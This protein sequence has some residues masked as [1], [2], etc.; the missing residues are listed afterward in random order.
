[1]PNNDVLRRAIRGALFANAAVAASVSMAAPADVP[2]TAT[3]PTA[4]PELAE[5]VVTGSRITDPTLKSISPVTTISSADIKE[6]GITRIEDLLNSMPQVF[7]DQGSNVSNGATGEAT[8]NLRN[9]GTQRTLVLINGRRLMPGD[10]TQPAA[11]AP[12]LNN[13]PAAL[14]DR[15]DVLTG[16]ASS[17]YGADAVAGVVNFVMNDHFEGVRLDVNAGLY[18]HSQHDTAVSSLVSQAGYPLPSSSVN[19]GQQRDLTFIIGSNLDDNKGNITAYAGYR[20]V[21]AV[22]E[23]QRDFSSCALNSANGGAEYRCGGSSTAATGRFIPIFYIAPNGTVSGANGL[24]G[25]PG[26]FTT[27]PSGIVPWGNQYEYNYAPTNYFQ[28]PDERWTAGSFAHYDFNEHQ[29]AY[30]EF[31]F[32]RD[33]SISQEAAGGAFIGEGNASLNGIPNGL[34]TTNCNNPLLSAA[35]VTALCNGNTAGSAQFYLGRRDVEGGPR[36]QDLEHTSFRVVVGTRGD[37]LDG[38]WHYDTY[39]MEGQT[40]Y[41]QSQTGNFSKTALGNALEVAPTGG[42]LSGVLGCVPYNVYSYG[43]VSTNQLKYLE[44]PAVTTG[45]TEERVIDANLTGDFGKYGLKSPWADSGVKANFGAEWRSEHVGLQVDAEQINF[46]ISG[47]GNPVYPLSAGF[48]VWEL[49]TEIGVPIAEDQP[50]AKSLAFETGYRYSN[51]NVGFSTN[52]FKFGLD[53]SPT[54]DFTFRGS[55]QRAVRAPNLQ[56]LFQQRFVG[57]DGSLDPCAATTSTPRTGSLLQCE[58]TGLSAAQYAKGPLTGNGSGQYNGFIGGNPTLKPEQSDTK[59]FGFVITPSA[60]PGFSV[61]LDY[62]DIRIKNVITSYGANFILT[63]CADTGNPTYCSLVH[64][65]ASGSLWLSPDGYVND[66]TLNLGSLQTRGMD[67]VT[68]YHL[69]MGAAGKMDFLLNGTYT[70]E[71]FTTPVPGGGEYDCAGYYGSTCGVP[72]PK[73]K[74]KF[75]ATWLTP[76]DGLSASL[77][78]RHINSVIE[79]THSPNPLLAGATPN[80][81]SGMPSF[82]Y[83]DLTA[84]YQVTKN[85]NLRVGVNNLFDKDPPIIAGGDFSTA[86]VNGNTWPQVYDTLGRY[87]FGQVTIDF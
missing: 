80:T 58:R 16:G 67:V 47:S 33:V 40:A 25:S 42:C 72:T 50:F 82:D 6:Q 18:N 20:R 56:E 65:D 17:V 53:W 23:S 84:A 55:F 4:E 5:V 15:V 59:S 39:A 3:T 1:M 8:V 79:D 13:I 28:R 63:Q 30:F 76:W 21:N 29:T 35:E 43:G 83:I 69:D 9:L 45:V 19:D 77:Q 86:F 68:N 32:M 51:Y 34:V 31:M 70:A 85:V 48:S 74:H 54:S 75:R 62:F 22:L 10:P 64:R 46:D 44:V 26:G 52:T 81:D 7:S 60:L 87:I 24:A 61:T 36:D 78:W 49:F 57:L 41:S 14:V 66:P 73:W 38:A 12:D 71:L 2:A 11:S 27:A 37:F